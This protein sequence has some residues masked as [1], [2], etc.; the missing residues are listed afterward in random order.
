MNDAEPKKEEGLD[1][2]K[3][4]HIIGPDGYLSNSLKGFEPREQQ[5]MMMRNVIDAYNK[6]QISL[7]EAGTG[8]GKSMAYL[9]PAMIW[10]LKKKE[11]TVISTNTITLQEQLIHK[12]IPMLT[13]ALQMDIKAVLVKGMSNYLCLRKLDDAKHE[14]SGLP[15]DEASEIE[16]IERW[17]ASTQDG[18]RSSL[19]MVPSSNTWERVCA[20]SDTCNHQQCPF[21]SKCFF[22][23]AR[24]EAEDAQ[25]LVANHHLL[26]ADLSVRAETNN[27]EETSILP[28][29]NRLILDEAHHIEDVATDFFGNSVS[30]LGILRL[31]SR[32]SSDKHNKL[33]GKLATLKDKLDFFFGITP[34]HD[35]ASIIM[36][37]NIDL[38]G[39][40]RELQELTTNTFQ[41]LAEF[42]ESTQAPSNSVG[43][44]ADVPVQE[45]KLRLLP[46][47]H[48]HPIWE[49]RIVPAGK[50]LVTSLKRYLQ[51]LTSLE[52][53]LKEINHDKFQEQAKGVRL[54]IAALAMRL[55]NHTVLIE[56]FLM[57]PPSNDKVRWI[58]EQQLRIMRNV[59]LSDAELDISNAL[60]NCLFSK[61]AT[62][63]LCSATLA[64]N[65]QFNFVRK[66]LGITETKLPDR[67]VTENIYDSPF[68][69]ATQAMLAIP[70]DV[71]FPQHPDFTK[72]A[73]EQ[74]WQAVQVSRGSTFVLFTS[75]GMMKSCHEILYNRFIDNR[76]HVFKQGD[77]NRQALLTKFKNTERSV[78]FGTDSFWEGVD[79]VGEA[80]RCVIIVKLPFKVPTEPIIQ[81]RTE[82]IIAS[83]GDP[84]FE[85]TLPNA[86]VK[87]KQG[88]GRLIRNK[89]DR[90]CI[91][92]LDTRLITKGYGKQFLNSLPA[93][94]Q[95]FASSEHV[96]QHMREFYRKTHHLVLNRPK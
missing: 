5:R 28:F 87:F 65:Q 56:R 55:S 96:E 35:A 68:D 37:L 32:L 42:I 52:V 86:I 10:A 50:K 14:L 62:I 83:G 89:R 9:I 39:M 49:S 33:Q 40:R 94:Q 6:D 19:S 8:T 84:F 61:F 51:A 53:D 80:L 79:V 60:V 15:I 7:I 44:Q 93:C 57:E 26:F 34:P 11:K 58:E 3:I 17:S 75:Y 31:L 59:S 69:Y 36:R 46:E 81:A 30:K 22:F 76:F 13:Q 70:T 43:E 41:A 66:R 63:V 54:D 95:V 64:T 92:C 72:E 90:G 18:S 20:E 12:D 27:Y 91:V 29:Y 47:H 1:T 2:E 71:P 48:T 85:Y 16:Q 73:A 38:P 24:R 21:F 23:K 67:F 45:S 74:I 88:F 4:L 77:D 78:L 82:A 25:I